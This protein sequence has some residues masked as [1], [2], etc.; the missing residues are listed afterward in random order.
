MSVTAASMKDGQRA[1]Q[2]RG[3]VKRPKAQK[4]AFGLAR[5]TDFYTD[6]AAF[7]DAKLPPYQ[8]LQDMQAV[9][10]KRSKTRGLATIYRA[11]TTLMEGHSG[12]DNAMSLGRALARY[13]PGSEAVMLVGS[14]TAGPD[15]LRKTFGELGT[16]LER[17]QKVRA[18]LRGAVISNAVQL[19][20]VLGMIIFIT[21]L[22][23]PQLSAGITKDMLPHLSFALGFFAF[24]K[25]FMAATPFVG[26]LLGGIGALVAWSLPR[27][28][29]TRRWW[30]RRWFDR[31]LIPYT[32]YVRAQATY[33]LSS[34]ASMMRAGIP[35]QQVIT[36]MMPFA[37]PWLRRHMNSMLK[38]LEKGDPP[39]QVL[40]SGFLPEDT[41]DR[42]RIYQRLPDF[43]EIMS[44]LSEDNFKLF[45]RSIDVL[46]RSMRL[47]GLLLFGAFI[48]SLLFAIFDYTNALYDS[49]NAARAA[50]GGA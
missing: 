25:A 2:G 31:H 37:S 30:N 9:A 3:A 11:I 8:A 21:Y 34:A 20:A 48:V 13:V 36:D 28:T 18:R 7:M 33:F 44:R 50:A 41:G 35:L 26:G 39:T 27:W 24:G 43:T 49:V 6:M 42:L 12:H 29:G 23:V 22:V 47:V 5:R 38:G 14:E 4:R 16:L 10:A 32:L 17:Q 15:V 46:S 45:E 19:G 1:G 40:S